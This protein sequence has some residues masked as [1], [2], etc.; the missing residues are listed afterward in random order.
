MK[1][2][3][4]CIG[5]MLAAISLALTSISSHAQPTNWML[6]NFDS[7]EVSATPYNTAWG[8]WFGGYFQGVSFDSTQDS[9]NNPNSGSMQLLLTCTGSDQYVLNDGINPAPNYDGNND[10]VNITTL[11]TNISFDMRYDV[12]SAIRTNANGTLDFGAMR[13]GSRNAAFAQDWYY[14]FTIS[15][16]NG[17]GLPNTNW[18]HMSVDLRQ[19]A[20]N[21]ADLAPGLIDIII[22]MDGANFGNN[23]LKGNQ[24]IWFDN[25]QYI[26]FAAP[27]PPPTV[28]IQ[29][30]TPALRMFGGNGVYGRSQVS[31]V[32]VNDGWIGGTYPVSYSFTLLGN[33][34]TPGNL[35]THIQFI[36]LDWDSSTYEGNSGADYWAA[37]ELWLRILSGTGT[38]SC[39]ADISWKTN[40]TFSN[41]GHTDLMITNSVRAGTW[42]LTFNSDTTGTLTAPGASPVPFTLSMS[43][44]DARNY[45]SGTNVDSTDFPITG[46]VGMGIRIGNM[47]NGNTANG[48]VPDDWTKISISGP[49][50]TNFNSNFTTM[51]SAQIDTNVW[52]LANSDGTSM[53]ILVPTNA[54]YWITWNTPDTGFALVTAAKLIGGTW[55]LPEFYNGYADGTNS[56]ATQSLHGGQ[57]WNLM[58][59]QYLPTANGSPGGPLAPDA[60]FKLINPPP[61]AP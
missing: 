11:F 51:T 41:P 16:T 4:L 20:A 21:F 46:N 30:T 18:I 10:L 14:N 43:A 54:H 2:I 26:G 13:I 7:D 38:S 39:V 12:S 59:P 57:Q 33:A 9:S 40:A 15:A 28:A 1:T 25:I 42:T 23:V 47:N 17:A 24:T 27:V 45:L 6:Y 44:A 48:G 50:G 56:V 32:D 35:D 8:N 61:A 60:F 58:L 29:T 36:P 55:L 53:Q 52:D 22:G 34:T 19:V 37:N 31:L 5:G 3:R 49:P